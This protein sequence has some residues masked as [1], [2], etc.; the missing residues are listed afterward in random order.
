MSILLDVVA[1]IVLIGLIMVSCEAFTNGIEW[2]GS[3]LGLHEGAV[4]GILAAIGT[5][6]PETLVPIVAILGVRLGAVS[7][8]STG[9]AIGEG[10]IVGSSFMLATLAMFVSGV[11][12][13]VFVRRGWREEWIAVEGKA[14]R[15]DLTFFLLS[16]GCAMA[17]S[18]LPAIQLTGGLTVKQ[19]LGFGFVAVYLWYTV[20]TLS[21]DGEV[22]EGLEP[23]Y[24]ASR[25]D[26]PPMGRVLAQVGVGL[27]AIVLGT[28]FFV[29]RI[30]DLATALRVP[31]LVLSLL[32]TPIAT[33]LPEK[34]NSVTWLKVKKDRLALGNITG[35][36]VFQSTVLVA[37][38]LWLTPW[39][40][41][42][43]SLISGGLALLSGGYLWWR[44]KRKV[45]AFTLLGCGSLYLVFLLALVVR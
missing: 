40:L 1:L 9:S 10:A 18:F 2:L 12:V 24:F 3:L 41:A 33:E 29:G 25:H 45:S 8:A 20:A 22:G 5:A 16:F 38:G 28:R 35:A 26:R 27:G 39:R 43:P 14:L 7:Q 31:P 13:V 32:I 21:A 37:V 19:A 44:A 34:Y 42:R 11:A 23:L 4:G 30:E 6:L 17:L 15:R 36:M